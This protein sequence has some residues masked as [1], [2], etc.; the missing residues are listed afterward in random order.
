MKFTIAYT[1]MFAYVIASIVF[2]GYSLNKQNILIYTL[3]K[4]KIEAEK[5]WEQIQKEEK[6]KVLR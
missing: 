5:K 3:E 2:W 1:L 6:V 4:E